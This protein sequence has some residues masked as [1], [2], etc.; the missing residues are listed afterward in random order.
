MGSLTP[1]AK[2]IYERDGGTVYAREFGKTERRVIG[3][4][5]PEHRDSLQYDILETQLWQD[6]V[7]AGKT[8]PALQ[9]TLD[10]AVLIYQTIKDDIETKT[11]P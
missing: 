3:Y 11:R 4:N 1:G 8:N 9:K 6:I 10:R 5:L 7:E 2:Y